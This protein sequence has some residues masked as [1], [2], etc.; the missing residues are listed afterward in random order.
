[1]PTLVINGHYDE[2]QDVCVE[3]FVKKIKGARWEKFM[4]SSH[5]CHIEERERY[6][7][8]VGDFLST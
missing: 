2:A 3:P 7:Q 5:L 6:M 8:V 1:V 4:E